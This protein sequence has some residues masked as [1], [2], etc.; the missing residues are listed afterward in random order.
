MPSVTLPITP[1]GPLIQVNI[2]IDFFRLQ[3]IKPEDA[4][5]R[6]PP[7][8]A[9]LLVDSGA[10]HT[11]ID[12]E[13]L[14]QLNLQPRNQVAVHTPSTNGVPHVCNQYSISLMGPFFVPALLANEAS[15]KAQGIHGLL[16]R[17][18][19]GGCVLTYNGPAR[20]FILSF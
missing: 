2:G 16:G 19:L 10:S 5:A 15:F 14:S 3:A 1:Q 4:A 13:I 8:Q 20:Q 9:S 7:V 11:T 18:V 12:P 17:D 6:R